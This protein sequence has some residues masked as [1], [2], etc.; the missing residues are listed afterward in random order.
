M[1]SRTTRHSFVAKAA[2]LLVLLAAADLLF[3]GRGPGWTLGLFTLA[4]PAVLAAAVRGVRRGAASVAPLVAAAFGLVLLDGPS[5]SAAALAWTGIASAALLTRTGFDGAGRWAPRLSAHGLAGLARP[6]VDAR[7]LMG[8]G[9]AGG[10]R[11]AAV[12]L[13]APGM[14]GLSFAL[15]FAAANPLIGAVLERMG[16]PSVGRLVFWVVVAALVRPSF[17][18]FVPRLAPPSGAGAVRAPE[19]PVATLVLSLLVFNAV[20]AVENALDLAFPWNGAALPAGVTLAAYAH[21]GAYP[22]IVTALLAGAFVLL[23]LRPGSAAAR[24]AA[25]RALVVV[26][27]VQNLLLVAS[28]AR[29]TLDYVEA[30]QMTVPRLSALAWMALV[31]VGLVLICRRLLAGRSARWLLDANALAAGIVLAGAAVVDLGAVAAA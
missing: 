28:S 3:R 18:P 12:P 15:L 31:A 4:W 24:S 23:A 9:R 25:V 27:I 17:R 5:P 26:W 6:P 10:L 30:Y 19:L 14:G 1:S 7:R 29:R 16:I 21:P 8:H 22:L 11:A 13:A 20:F 2:G